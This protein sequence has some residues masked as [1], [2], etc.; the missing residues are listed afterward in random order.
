[1]KTKINIAASVFLICIITVMIVSYTIATRLKNDA[2]NN[3]S[4]HTDDIAVNLKNLP[5]DAGYADILSEL[6]AEADTYTVENRDNISDL[7]FD[8]QIISDCDP[9]GFVSLSAHYKGIKTNMKITKGDSDTYSRLEFIVFPDSPEAQYEQLRHDLSGKLSEVKISVYNNDGELLR[10]SKTFCIGNTDS[11]WRNAIYYDY[12][13][14]EVKVDR[15]SIS[16]GEQT[17][18]YYVFVILFWLS[19][20]SLF[21]YVI[22]LIISYVRRAVGSLKK[23]A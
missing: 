17:A 7:P 19:V 15:T 20:L 8:T 14:D 10:T 13:T 5:D 12:K 23:S 2:S 16:S 11:S 1:M 3:Y 6:D 18:R 21:I 4:H 9:D 22:A